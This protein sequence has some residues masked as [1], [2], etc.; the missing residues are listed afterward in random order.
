[1]PIFGVLLEFLGRLGAANKLAF[2]AAN[3]ALWMAFAIQAGVLFRKLFP[4]L[5]TYSAVACCLTLA[6][7]VI[8]TQLCTA[9]VVLPANLA[10]ILSYA[11]ILLLLGTDGAR[12]DVG[13]LRYSGAML[14]AIGGVAISEYGVA[15]N[16]AG[17]VLMAGLS[18]ISSD[19][20]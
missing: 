5:K 10:T 6:P 1:R 7:I 17:C 8:Q 20:D 14:L 16:L 9:L 13:P 19:F 4:E 15:T 11:A 3:A 2:V 12:E 18:L